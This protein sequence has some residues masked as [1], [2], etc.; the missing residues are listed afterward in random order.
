LDEAINF[1]TYYLLTK[2]IAKIKNLSPLRVGAGKGIRIG[3]SDLPIIRTAD[4]RAVVP[5]SSL[6]G[7]FRNNIARFL[8]WDVE[9]E[10]NYV[11]GGSDP[12]I[13]SSIIFSDFV[14][15]Q[16]IE[17]VE[18]THIRINLRTGGVRNMFQAE[19]A[20]ED[21]VFIGS[22]MGRNIPLSDL[23]IMI[24]LVT[25]LMNFGIVRIGGFK[26][27]GYGLVSFDIDRI[28]VILPSDD[29]RY[30]TKLGFTKGGE[31]EVRIKVEKDQLK[32]NDKHIFSSKLASDSQLF[33]VY[34]I[35]KTSFYS[36]GDGLLQEIINA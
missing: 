34:E 6:K 7:V 21:N 5:G 19:Y 32:E 33:K 15:E 9:K 2:I 30:T 31:R 8:N 29:L 22:M 17:N 10:L 18:R 11:F 24:S 14:S 28:Q 1:K 3:E 12:P 36:V 26:S 13:G 16:A 35:D 4:R 23:A 25:K 27:R 20:P